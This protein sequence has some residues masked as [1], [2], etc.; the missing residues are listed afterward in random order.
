[1]DNLFVLPDGL[2]GEQEFFE[3]LH[4]SAGVRIERILSKGHTTPPG[5]WYDQDEDEWV[6]LLEGDAAIAY[7]DGSS[8]NLSPG[9]YLYIPAH[10][11]HRVA[12]TSADPV[13]V[14]LAV[15]IKG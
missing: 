3:D 5:E 13:C 8:V 7:D 15:H 4:A 1:M 14:W 9:D 6:A 2:R 12:R 10:R 11:R